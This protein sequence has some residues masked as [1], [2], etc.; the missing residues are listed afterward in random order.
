MMK[1]RIAVRALLAAASLA[2]SLTAGCAR[3][4]TPSSAPLSSTGAATA[5]SVSAAGTSAATLAQT[6]ASAKRITTT[7]GKTARTTKEDTTMTNTTATQQSPEPTTSAEKPRPRP[8]LAGPQ[9]SQAFTNLTYNNAGGK[10]GDADGPAYC[11]YSKIGYNRAS[12]DIL[13]SE[14]R[15]NLYRESDMLPLTAYIFLGVDIY[16][17]NGQWVNCFDAGL[18]FHNGKQKWTLFHNILKVPPTQDKWYM[19]GK[20]LDDTHD[21]RIVLDTSFKDDWAALIV[22][23]LTEGGVEYDRATFRTLYTRKDG[24]NTAYLQD[25]A[26]DFPDNVKYNTRGEPAGNDWPEITL[27]NTDENIYMKSLRIVGATLNGRPWT[28]E[29][30][31]NRAVWP[32]CTQKKIQYPV[33]RLSR[34]SFDTELQLDFDMNR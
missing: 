9:G 6:T 33:V 13:L 16:D 15:H 10:M 30:T 19:S 25:Y 12:I 20:Y 8:T 18:G 1:K 27:Y 31:A 11:V 23:D 4:G 26:L 3:E 17:A 22:Y 34:A 7:T 24:S 2:L 29:H 32:D 14:L 5:C 21:Y 28:Q